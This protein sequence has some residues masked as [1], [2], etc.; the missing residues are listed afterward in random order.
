MLINVM[1]IKGKTCTI[2]QNVIEKR[3][4]FG[5]QTY[6]K[7]WVMEQKNQKCLTT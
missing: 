2:D 5:R 6:I 7:F 1:L 3:N 4:V